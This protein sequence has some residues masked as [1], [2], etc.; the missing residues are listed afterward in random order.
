VS[1][2]E[3]FF[4]VLGVISLVGALGVVLSRNIVHA[5]LFLLLAL[6]TIAGLYI[7]LFS[8]FL[9][10]VQVLIYGGAITVVILFAVMLTR[11][12]ETPVRLNN[13]QRPLAL[14][15]GIGAF[16]VLTAVILVNKW[17]NT[18]EEIEPVPFRPVAETLFTTWAVPFEVASVLLLVALIGAIVI[19]RPGGEEE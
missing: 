1:P 2:A 7:V 11:T 12:R 13:N 3:A 16:A 18:V 6:L 14:V 10:L 17:P 9:A 15:A 5:A 4:Y 8:E 19:A